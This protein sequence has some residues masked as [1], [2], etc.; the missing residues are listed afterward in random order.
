MPE[1]VR[2]DSTLTTQ[3]GL[4]QSTKSLAV[5]WDDAERKENNE[6]RLKGTGI[7]LPLHQHFAKV[8]PNVTANRKDWEEDRQGQDRSMSSLASHD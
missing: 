2:L 6:G 1:F 8:T 5:G 7:K 4:Q 3:L